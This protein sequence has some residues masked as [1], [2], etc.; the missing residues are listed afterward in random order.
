MVPTHCTSGHTAEQT[1]RSH[2]GFLSNNLLAEERSR[3][4]PNLFNL[5]VSIQA[6]GQSRDNMIVKLLKCA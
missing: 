4:A 5:L 2:N 3:S 1:W 6:Q